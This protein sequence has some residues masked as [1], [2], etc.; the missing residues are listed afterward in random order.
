LHVVNGLATVD[1]EKCVGCGACAKVCP[2]NIITITPFKSDRMLAVTCSNK[3]KG[4][5][6]I[7]VCNVGCIGC[8]ACARTSSLF[9]LENNLSTI[10]YDAYSPTCSL[11]V[12]EACKKCKRHR[13]VFVGKPTSRRIL[14]ALDES[15]ES[16]RGVSCIGA[17]AGADDLE[18]SLCHCLKPPALPR[19]TSAG[20]TKTEGAQDWR[21][22]HANRFRPY[23]DEAT[24]R[25]VDAGIN[26]KQISRDFI[27]VRINTIQ[28]IMEAAV[29]RKFG[30]I[31]VGRRKAATFVQ[32]HLRGRFSE[33][34][35]NSVNTMAVWVVS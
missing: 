7:A 24:Q 35:I 34:I 18:I 21:T 11:D 14:V 13:L 17:L 32:E 8:G 1:Y 25:L 2:R 5:D 20:Y 22:Y 31:V 33:K 30:T 15:I 3:D 19:F 16:M 27:F 9:K 23:M 10:D 12:L 4:K 26:A 29:N 28:E 6:V